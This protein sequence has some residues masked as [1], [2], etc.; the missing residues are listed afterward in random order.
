M[1]K[2]Y[3]RLRS[4]SVLC[5]DAVASRLSEITATWPKCTIAIFSA[6]IL[7][8]AFGLTKLRF[9]LNVYNMADDNM[10]SKQELLR[11]QDSF[12]DNKSLLMSFSAPGRALSKSEICDL[13]HWLTQAQHGLGGILRFQAPWRIMKPVLSKDHLVY[14]YARPLECDKSG[15]I[16]D[17]SWLRET[18]VYGFLT[19]QQTRDLAIEVEFRPESED[20]ARFDTKVVGGLVQSLQ[21]GFL[22]QHPQLRLHMI[23]D[24]AFQWH[25][26]KMLIHDGLINPLILL[27]FLFF[28]RFFYGTWRAGGIFIGSLMAMAIVIYGL[29]G[30]FA[31]P[32]D[33]LSNNIFLLIAIGSAE[34]FL[35]VSYMLMKHP[36]QSLAAQ[37]RR[38]FL[39]CFFTSLTT[40]V[41]FGSLLSSELSV[42]RRFG[43]WCAAGTMIE[44]AFIFLALPAVLKLAG[45]ESGW[46]SIGRARSP[47]WSLAL[48]RLS[49]W[50][51][52]R[53]IAIVSFTAA[54]GFAPRIAVNDSPRATFP[55]THLHT[56][57][58]H[59][60]RESRGW[61]GS[62][63]LQFA[64][65]WPDADLHRDNDFFK[66]VAQL[67]NVARVLG[68]FDLADWIVA[69]IE[70][71]AAQMIKNEYSV[72]PSQQRFVTLKNERR[73][74]IFLR[75]VDYQDLQATVR[76]LRALCAPARCTPVGESVVFSEYSDQVSTTLIYSFVLSLGLVFLIIGVLMWLYDLP[77]KTALLFSSAWAPVM[78]LGVMGLLQIPINLVTCLFPTILVGLAGDNAIQYLFSAREQKKPIGERDYRLVK[79]IDSR[80]GA[81]VQMSILFCLASTVLLLLTFQQ[82]KIVG[83]LFIS[84]FAF[85]L[86]GDL[87]ILKGL[88]P[89]RSKD[90]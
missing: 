64:S 16:Y 88:L 31:S 9:E 30:L 17:L 28:F 73:A 39:P 38:L 71:V 69:G 36:E 22:D 12:S 25:F 58:F 76:D 56:R 32:I 78:M 68:P 29:M 63:Y 10:Q 51:W 47:R 70:P 80:A 20:R 49:P 59:Y 13:D 79:G 23:G 54:I 11:M 82:F 33:A 37:F 65:Q 27:I 90:R 61:E 41:G 8:C 35:L 34:D 48:E 43:L 77:N 74:L 14:R 60:F 19:D 66:R 3:A 45:S 44:F 2:A 67:P 52:L 81:S 26:K 86:I 87:W 57:S 89:L 4:Q 40:A 85:M 15:D 53:V 5:L 84:G 18:P 55:E 7:L 46:V 42:I 62:I 72:L 6:I 21:A 24:G 1:S 50:R 75:S 83:L